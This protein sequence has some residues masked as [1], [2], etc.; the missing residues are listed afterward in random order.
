MV[1]KCIKGPSGKD[2]ETIKVE[3]WGKVT[4]SSGESIEGTLTVPEGYYF[5]AVAGLACIE[6][7]LDNKVQP[8]C[9]TPSMAFGADFITR[10]N[11][12]TLRAHI[13]KK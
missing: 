6:Q 10:L 8:G 5:T 4:N 2:H 3:L 9:W 12:T 13:N 7:V 11:G 1:E